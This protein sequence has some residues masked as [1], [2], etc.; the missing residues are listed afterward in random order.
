M[1]TCIICG[2]ALHRHRG[3]RAGRCGTCA[4]YH[5]RHGHDRPH[6]LI[7]TLTQKDIERALTRRANSC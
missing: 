7:A 1:R 4:T 2:D 3:A 5:Y 6:H